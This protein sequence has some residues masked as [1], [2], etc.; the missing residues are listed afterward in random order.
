MLLCC[1]GGCLEISQVMS[2]RKDGSGSID[3]TYV[4]PDNTA[5]QM[6]AAELLKQE[7]IKAAGEKYEPRP[8]DTH[9]AL[10]MD[11][12]DKPIRDLI[13]RCEPYGITLERLKIE[14]LEGRRRVRIHLR[15]SDIAKAAKSD[16][17]RI[18]WPV[19]LV[20]H[21]DGTYQLNV[22]N[23]RP[24]DEPELDFSDPATLKAITPVLRGFKATIRINTPGEVI[25]TEASTVGRSSAVWTFNFNEDPRAFS[26]FKTTNM[27][28][29]FKGEGLALPEIKA[30]KPT[31]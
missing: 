24:A 28:I 9:Y 3:L 21:A 11:P 13:A 1:C 6:K 5:A 31:P 18:H 26:T 4:L 22:T 17:F 7:M 10:F 8:V 2:I 12:S 30:A 27:S 19:T 14:V 16:I 15:F 29:R 20:K 25:S 23:G